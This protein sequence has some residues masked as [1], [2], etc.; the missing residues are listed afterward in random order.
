MNSCRLIRDERTAPSGMIPRVP[1]AANTSM[2]IVVEGRDDLRRLP[3]LLPP[4]LVPGTI[5]M[6][7]GA[8]GVQAT[9]RTLENGVDRPFLCI[10]DRD[11]MTDGDVEKLC[12]NLPGLFV[13]SSRC[14]ENE[15]L[16]P[17]LL[18]HVLTIT[19]HPDVGESRV[20]AALREIADAQCEEILAVLVNTD[21]HR[22]HDLTLDRRPGETPINRMLRGH[23]AKRDLA[24]RRVR[25][26]WLRVSQSERWLDDHWDQQHL[27]LLDGKAALTRVGHILGANFTGRG[28]E[29]A[30]IYQALQE[31][32]PGVAALREAIRKRA[33]A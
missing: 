25:E 15:P 7:D 1:P 22:D 32:S 9:C 30:L 8:K 6:A 23:E 2:L 12:R 28:L 5:L 14:L 26:F 17:P 33:G 21:M 29:Q 3:L 13:W 31:P 27:R 18:S 24:E 4:D 10:C 20:R 19:G 11:L 16:H